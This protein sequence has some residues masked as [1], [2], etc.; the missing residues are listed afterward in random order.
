MKCAVFIAQARSLITARH[1]HGQG[2]NDEDQEIIV[3][4]IVI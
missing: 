4:K 2:G 1:E 3:D